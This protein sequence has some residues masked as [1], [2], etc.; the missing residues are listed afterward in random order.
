[1]WQIFLFF[2]FVAKFGDICGKIWQNLGFQM[3]IFHDASLICFFFFKSSLNRCI[4]NYAIPLKCTN[5]GSKGS[6]LTIMLHNYVMLCR[7]FSI[8]FPQFFVVC[9]EFWEN[10]RKFGSQEGQKNKPNQNKNKVRPQN[11]GYFY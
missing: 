9:G 6:T 4:F 7:K 11:R 3:A 10:R 1:M 5:V 2:F 8:V